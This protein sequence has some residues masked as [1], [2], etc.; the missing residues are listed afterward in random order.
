MLEFIKFI[1]GILAS[2]VLL[3]WFF[4]CVKNVA[5]IYSSKPKPKKGKR[6]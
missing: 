4:D 5:Y 2:V 1:L 3:G 6:R